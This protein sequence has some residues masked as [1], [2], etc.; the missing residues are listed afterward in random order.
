MSKF[1]MGLGIVLLLAG[2]GTFF[3]YPAPVGVFTNLPDTVFGDLLPVLS[4]FI[5]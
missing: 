1:F 3:V 5:S 2:I 4:A